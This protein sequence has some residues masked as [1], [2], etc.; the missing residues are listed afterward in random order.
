MPFLVTGKPPREEQGVQAD[1]VRARGSLRR[2][3]GSEARRL[4]PLLPRFRSFARQPPTT[5]SCEDRNK[6]VG[7]VKYEVEL[8]WTVAAKGPPQFDSR[9][10]EKG[11][12]VPPP[13]SGTDPVV[14]TPL[15]YIRV[16]TDPASRAKRRFWGT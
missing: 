3:S 4:H 16:R 15:N 9:T 11:T 8:K 14:Y 1:Y 13:Q 2:V 12:D 7:F 5:A 6:Y 10:I